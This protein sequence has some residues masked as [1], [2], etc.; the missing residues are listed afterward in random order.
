MV[1]KTV[2]HYRVLEK[3]GGGG[4]G[5]VYKAEDRKLGRFVALKF[6]PGEF[7]RDRQAMER[8]RREARSASTLNHPHICTIYEFDEYEG[9]PFI[10]M[11][12][13]EG[14]TLQHLLAGGPLS[15][16]R[17]LELGIQIVDALEA[18]H[19]KGI[20]HRD[21]KPAN[22]F[23]TARGHAKILDFGLAKNVPRGDRALA[24]A[25]ASDLPT[26]IAEENLTS[27]GSAVGTVAYMAPEQARG[28]DLDARADL[29]SFG[30][31]LY[32][33]ATSRQ[34]FPGNT[35][36]VI[37]DAILN[38]DPVPPTR[39]N[40]DLPQDVERVIA[41]VLE[42]D[43][44]MRH[45]TAAELRADLKRAERD[46]ESAAGTAGAGAAVRAKVPPR[47]RPSRVA[48]A[49][50]TAIAL[51]VLGG[52][53]LLR[54]RAASAP[55]RSEWTQLTHFTDSVTSPAL[56]PDGHMLTF[57]HGPDTFVGPGQIY[58]KI[59]PDG[60]PVKLTDD[61]LEKMSPVFSPDGSR[62]AYTAIPWDSWIVPVL[63]GKPRLWLPNASGL[64]WVDGE[65]ILF[66]EIKK[67]NHM[68]LATAT[69]SR[70]ESHDVYVPPSENGMA[71]RSCLSPDRKWVL[72]VEMDATS[73]LPCRLLPFDASSV[74]KPVGPPGGR[75]TSAAW[76]P[77]GRWMYL[78][79]DTGG[80][81]HIWRQL[82][83]A[84]APEQVT[85]GATQEEGIAMA[86]DGRSFV[87]SVGIVESSIWIHDER[88]GERQV[89]TEGFA[90]FGPMGS[91]PFLLLGRRQEAL[92]LMRRR[93]AR[94][95]D[96]G[97]LWTTEL[98]SGT[99]SVFCRASR[100]FISISRAMAGVSSSRRAM[101]VASCAS[102]SL[103]PSAV[104]LR[105][106]SHPLTI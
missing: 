98:D 21:I 28:E 22:I 99:P 63:G 47:M 102:G 27:P 18:A 32:E 40:P 100:W 7:S 23:V 79:V 72:A 82:F 34:A 84:G 83:P 68:A 14:Q 49:A 73:W 81:S 87:T 1:G 66:S 10:A 25:A 9:Q 93:A 59:L 57:L 19:V 26:E 39:W 54:S 76:S 11:E 61:A 56:S 33:M 69:E 75:C 12:L 85:S 55:K 80:G 45:Q 90:S 70:A 95:F 6:V 65:H 44:E 74:G 62:I 2:S 51:L 50:V 48:V 67:G 5:V 36:A 15:T 77:D 8:M 53:W 37:H 101:E 64:T 71:H 29:F 13:L 104:S 103:L 38:R 20:L 4:M 94:E 97:E 89:S 17:L 52:L 42:K 41:K 88:S 35:A 86:P 92:L 46:L 60:E 30:A 96:D 16:E 58:V 3:L 105:G 106:G 24:D 43:R 78:S 91:P 31:V